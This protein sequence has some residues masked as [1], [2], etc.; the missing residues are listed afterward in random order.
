[1]VELVRAG[2]S[3]AEL[4]QKFE[5]SAAAIRNW[6]A[7][8]DR[9]EGRR[10]TAWPRRNGRSSCA[11]AARIACS[12]KSL[13]IGRARRLAPAD[14]EWM[15][16]RAFGASPASSPA[17]RLRT[18]QGTHE[19]PGTSF[20]I[21][22]GPDRVQSTHRDPSRSPWLSDAMCASSPCTGSPFGT[23]KMRPS[24][25]IGPRALRTV[26]GGSGRAGR[27]AGRR[28]FRRRGRRCRGRA[29]PRAR[30]RRRSASGDGPRARASS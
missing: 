30:R 24:L 8:A 10:G 13:K 1:M 15:S 29:S 7:Q 18:S 14:V 20:A 16:A 19:P 21:A 26:S 25:R 3:P 5:P 23:E 9:D 22:S 17:P 2:R 27:L 4:A 12:G 28:W 11:C 6:V